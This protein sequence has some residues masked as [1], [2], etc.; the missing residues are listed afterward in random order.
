MGGQSR[1]RL[2]KTDCRRRNADVGICKFIG[3]QCRGRSEGGTP[4]LLSRG[5][6]ARLS[7]R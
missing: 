5:I 1:L 4:V 3:V 6:T 2:P 7:K